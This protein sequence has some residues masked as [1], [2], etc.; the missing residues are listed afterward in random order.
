MTNQSQSVDP[1]R[2]RPAESEASTS[3]RAKYAGKRLGKFQIV[4]ELGRG[5]MGVV[6]EAR[7]TVLDRHVAIKL[8]PRSVCT[9]PDALE[10]FLREARAAAKLNHPHVV[11][12][13]DAD[14]FNG[15]YY[16]VLELVRGGNLQDSL[17]AGPL[18]WH[19]ATRVLADAC[20]GL[21]VAHRSGLV[22][23]DIKPSN[24]MRSEAGTVKLADFGLVRPNESTGATMTG[25]GSVL[26][27]P[28]YMSPEQCRSERA[29]ERSDLYSM[30]ATYFALLTGRPP[31]PGAAP[32]LVMNAHLLDPIPN[33]CDFDATIPEACSLIIQRAMAKDPDD[34]YSSAAALIADLESLL[35]ETKTNVDDTAGPKS[36]TLHRSSTVSVIVEPDT[37]TAADPT[38]SSHWFKHWPARKIAIAGVAIASVVMALSVVVG[39]WK[40]T[41]AAETKPVAGKKT[42]NPS[43]PQ[44]VNNQGLSRLRPAASMPKGAFQLPGMHGEPQPGNS[45]YDVWS[46]DYPGISRVYLSNSG[47]FLVVL[48]NGASTGKGPWQSQVTVWNRS[49]KKLLDESLHGRATGGAISGDNTRL[50]VGTTGGQGVFVWD[51]NSWKRTTSATRKSPD[52]VDAVALSQDGRWLAYTVTKSTRESEWVLWDLAT[53]KES[54]RRAVKGAGTMRAIEFAPS[55]DLLVATGGS[56]G[57]I[58]NW[59]GTQTELLSQTFNAGQPIYAIAFRP[60]EHLQVTGHGRSFSLWDY[61]RNVRTFQANQFAVQVDDVTFSPDGQYA[62]IAAGAMVEIIDAVTG[63]AVDRMACFNSRVLSMAVIPDGMGIFAASADGKLKLC[64]V[65]P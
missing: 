34:R 53:Q 30:G 8:L 57:L 24:L 36:R 40:S 21:D 16:I 55:D 12:V 49:G 56:D 10:R 35:S 23:R 20:R 44:Q 47:E 37:P 50:A 15:Q 17:K 60:G 27:T 2:S 52:Y 1:G 42:V 26:G 19:E 29:D 25:S 48:T 7:D 22:H 62:Y 3:Q 61:Q 18:E 59:R 5:G 46:M 63:R 65:A 45:K 58:R 32:L 51:T 39:W 38:D 4:G 31:F 13:Y 28:Q 14:Q 54:Q 43:R 64:R 11:G 9:Q 41:R 6:F 33:P